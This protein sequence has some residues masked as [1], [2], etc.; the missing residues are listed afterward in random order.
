MARAQLGNMVGVS[1]RNIE[2][3]LIQLYRC[4]SHDMILNRHPFF[5]FQCT[6]NH[7]SPFPGPTE[8]KSVKSMKMMTIFWI[9]SSCID[10]CIY[11]SLG[12]MIAQKTVDQHSTSWTNLVFNRWWWLCWWWWWW[13][14]WWWYEDAHYGVLIELC[15]E[16]LHGCWHQ[17]WIA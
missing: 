10:P 5:G 7:G 12:L 15:C 9:C 3:D 2:W 14:W 6:Q 17:T 13:W 1:V 16:Y 8:T 11:R 4:W